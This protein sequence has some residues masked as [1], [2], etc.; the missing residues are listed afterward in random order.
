MKKIY[1]RREPGKLPCY[2]SFLRSPG[3]AGFR[4]GTIALLSMLA[5]LSI[6]TACISDIEIKVPETENTY[7]IEGWIE[8]GGFA[9]VLVSHSLPYNSTI[10]I[11]DLFELL[12]TDAQVTVKSDTGEERLLLVEDTM[13]TILP[14][15][16]GFLLRGETGKDYTLEVKI[17][18]QV[19][20]STDTLLEPIGPDSLWFSPEAINDSL[21]YIHMRL[22]DPPEP[23]NYYRIFTKRLGIDT[24]Y[25]GLSGSL[26]D[27]HLFNGTAIN[28]PLIR[29]G[30]TTET[31]DKH[32]F[33]K[34]QRVVVKTGVITSRY[35]DFLS[36]VSNE[37][38]QTLSP[39][40][41][42]VP[43]VTL[44]NGGAL[45]GWGCYA[46]TLDT[47]DIK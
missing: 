8:Q 29:T 45:G 7:V 1:Y 27:D 13:Y 30:I 43:A 34:G 17:G 32:F 39:L 5:M 10:G 28:F 14:V 42:Q 41:F 23:G 31:G 25:T 18:D 44:M 46:I 6:L 21:G 24:D 26:L 3:Q 2:R 38:G 20:T 47:L 19:F 36:K 4:K 22:K 12:V 16:R 9:H 11:A 35:F 40:S 37:I 33:R 15:Y